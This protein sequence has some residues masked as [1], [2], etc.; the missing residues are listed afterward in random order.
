MQ[1]A[2]FCSAIW[3][4]F[5]FITYANGRFIQKMANA[6]RTEKYRLLG[7]G[8]QLTM[9][10]VN[11]SEL[12]TAIGFNALTSHILLRTKNRCEDTMKAFAFPVIPVVH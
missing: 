11:A 5:D 12:L 9:A 6:S 10:H 2:L 1:H 3:C 8:D 7:L 4:T